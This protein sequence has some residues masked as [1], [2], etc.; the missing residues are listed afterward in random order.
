MQE[1]TVQQD[2]PPLVRKVVKAKRRFGA[3]DV[4]TEMPVRNLWKEKL[5]SHVADKITR[6]REEI[7]AREDDLQ[8]AF[9]KMDVSPTAK[10]VKY[11]GGFYKVHT[12]EKGGKFIMV[13]GEKKYLRKK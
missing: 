1:S 13:H 2:T 11:Q 4:A 3:V 8:A 9:E 10:K 6:H 12:G 7:K 5:K